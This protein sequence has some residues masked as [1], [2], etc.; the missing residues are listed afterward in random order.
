MISVSVSATPLDLQGQPMSSKGQRVSLRRLNKCAV[1]GWSITV[2]SRFLTLRLPYAT[3]PMSTCMY[4]HPGR[5]ASTVRPCM[6]TVWTSLK[7]AASFCRLLLYLVQLLFLFT[8]TLF[9][10]KPTIYLF[11]FISCCQHIVDYIVSAV[12]PRWFVTVSFP[13]MLNDSKNICAYFSFIQSC[14][15][16]IPQVNSKY[17]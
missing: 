8:F 14:I 10:T 9:I 4:Y 13:H 3:W 12:G 17:G 1:Y 16:E 2:P 7:R 6:F 5:Y 15:S 11:I